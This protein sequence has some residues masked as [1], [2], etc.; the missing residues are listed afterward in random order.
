LVRLASVCLNA[1]ADGMVCSGH[2][3]ETLRHQFGSKP[4]FMCP[5]IRLLGAETHDQKRVVSPETAKQLGAD[6]IVMGR[7]L[8]NSFVPRAQVGEILRRLE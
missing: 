8:M 7:S 4:V 5:G 6:Y 2:E 3:L 1:G